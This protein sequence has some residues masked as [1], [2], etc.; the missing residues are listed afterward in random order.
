M[1]LFLHTICWCL[2]KTKF[3]AGLSMYIHVCVVKGPSILVFPIQKEF[4]S[5]LQNLDRNHVF[6]RAVQKQ[7]ATAP[8][9]LPSM[10]DASFSCC[11]GRNGRFTRNPPS[12]SSWKSRTGSI[13]VAPS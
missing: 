8:W 3:I 4:K 11:P 6:F 10:S 7:Q 12:R 13:D 9:S 2:S 1:L 5:S